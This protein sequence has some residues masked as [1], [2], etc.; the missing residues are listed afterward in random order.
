MIQLQ[1]IGRFSHAQ[2]KEQ[3]NTVPEKLTQ[4]AMEKKLKDFFKSIFRFIP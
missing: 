3:I 4:I 1:D 2:R